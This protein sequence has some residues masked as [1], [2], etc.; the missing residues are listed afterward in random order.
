MKRRTFFKNLSVAGTS[1]LAGACTTVEKKSKG[2]KPVKRVDGK[3]DPRM[4]GP[5]PILSTPFTE[6]GEVDYNTLAREAKFVS[7]CGCNMIWPQS[8][9]AID[10]LSTEEK[11][12]GMQVIADALQGSKSTV[13]FGCNGKNIE[14]MVEHVKHVELLADKYKNTNIALISR[15]ADNTQNQEDAKKYFLE[16]EKYTSRP[17]IIQTVGGN[18]CKIKAVD[19]DILIDLAKR[20]PKVFGYIKEETGNAE[21]CNLRMRKEISAK[22][23]IH[24]VYS[25]WGGWQWLYQ[26]RRIGSEGLVSERA[27]YADLLA[28]IWEQVENGDIN[29]TLSDAFSK[30]L[31][32]YNFSYYAKGGTSGDLRGAHLYVF[33]KRGVFK[34]RLSREYIKKNRK[35]IVPQ[36]PI[37]KDCKLTQQQIDEIDTCLETISKYFKV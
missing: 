13:A 28:Y 1:A 2:V 18:S 36:T 6:S 27:V 19:V 34:N 7:D 14:H 29:G 12:K 4:R 35:L 22:P 24:T 9:A 31:L 30:L 10:L 8:N 15:P 17:T 32:A 5:F 37:I 11:F 16:L 21:E 20:N 26:M 3:G 33:Q 23:I 25:A